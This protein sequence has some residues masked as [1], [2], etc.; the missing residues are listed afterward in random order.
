MAEPSSL[1][2][3][4]EVVFWPALA[5]SVPWRA[6]YKLLDSIAHRTSLYE[7]DADA[8]LAGASCVTTIGDSADWKR[9]YRLTRLIDY[10]DLFLARTRTARWFAK[11]VDVIGAWPARGPFIAMTF[12]WGAGLWS[13]E[14]MH[15][16]GVPVHFVAVRTRREEFGKDWLAYRYARA[17]NRTVERAGGAPIIYTGGATDSIRRALADGH[18]VVAL[19]DVPAPMTGRTLQTKVCDRAIRLPAGMARLAVESH[20]TVVAFEM[21]I[22]F[23]TGRRKLRIEPPFV[24]TSEQDFA[25]RL[26]LIM[27]RVLRRDSAAWHFSHLAKH[28]FGSPS[29][30]RD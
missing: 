2:T 23:A 7:A 6:G 16:H 4:R 21:G 11:H 12:H 15:S 19:Y 25:D 20:A 17:R 29:T 9:R 30:A 18:A 14:H 26:A 28:F 13:I 8:A 22:D 27:T 3:L 24:A 5:A 1:R 10:C